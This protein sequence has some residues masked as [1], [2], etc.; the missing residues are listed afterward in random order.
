MYRTIAIRPEVF[1][2]MLSVKSLYE[3]DFSRKVS[4]S[5][6]LISLATGYCLGRAV[7]MNENSYKLTFDD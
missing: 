5:E 6:F 4:W 2:K 3:Q 1:E 7:V